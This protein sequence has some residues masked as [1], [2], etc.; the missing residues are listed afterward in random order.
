MPPIPSIVP[1]IVGRYYRPL[2]PPE[3]ISNSFDFLSTLPTVWAILWDA[4]RADTMLMQSDQMYT[5]STH[6]R[7]DGFGLKAMA[8]VIIRVWVG[9]GLVGVSVTLSNLSGVSPKLCGVSQR[10][11]EVSPCTSDAF[12]GVADNSGRFGMFPGIVVTLLTVSPAS[13]DGI[14]VADDSRCIGDSSESAG[15]TYFQDCRWQIWNC[16]DGAEPVTES[17]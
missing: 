16:T 15:G 1:M 3:S 5:L 7:I 8:R 9:E 17:F 13:V 10:V 6:T 14:F 11:P 12:R 4:F 2:I